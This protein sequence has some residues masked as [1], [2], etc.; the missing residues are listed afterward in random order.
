MKSTWT[1]V[2]VRN[3]ALSSACYQSLLGLPL[4]Q[5]AHDYFGQIGDADAGSRNDNS[6]VPV[7]G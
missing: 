3:V 5:P 6:M 7:L 4:E 1:I 2:G